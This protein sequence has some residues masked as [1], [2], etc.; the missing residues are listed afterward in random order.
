MFKFKLYWCDPNTTKLLSSIDGW[1]YVQCG[2]ISKSN[3][4]IRILVFF[5]TTEVRISVHFQMEI[6]QK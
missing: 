5:E 6:N 2:I 1:K 3:I 4:L